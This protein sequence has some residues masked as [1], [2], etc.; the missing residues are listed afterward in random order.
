MQCSVKAGHRVILVLYDMMHD[1]KLVPC[2]LLRTTMSPIRFS[3]F[4]L[5]ASRK[6]KAKETKS[7]VSNERQLIL[8]KLLAINCVQEPPVTENEAT[9]SATKECISVE[10][11]AMRVME[12]NS[13]AAVRR[14]FLHPALSLTH[15]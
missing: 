3:R 14:L 4:P 13:K 12:I 11:R 9:V 5:L 15:I 7:K 1:A 6:T 8:C 10:D 2:G